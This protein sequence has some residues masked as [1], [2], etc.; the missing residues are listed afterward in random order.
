MVRVCKNVRNEQITSIARLHH[1]F[2]S[3]YLAA[4]EHTARLNEN[5]P[6]KQVLQCHVNCTLGPTHDSSWRRPPCRPRM[7]VDRPHPFGHSTCRSVK[8]RYQAWL[9]QATRIR[10]GDVDDDLMSP[11]I[12]YC[13]SIDTPNEQF[14]RSV[15]AACWHPCHKKTEKTATSLSKLKYTS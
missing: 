7:T 10:V 5:V 11:S 9:S 13:I 1:Q 3:S 14:G 6:A 12:E 4:F 2:Q 15:L 8:A